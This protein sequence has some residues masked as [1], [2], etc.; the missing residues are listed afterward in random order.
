MR[1]RLRGQLLSIPALQGAWASWQ[2]GR[3]HRTYARRRE[4]YA[5]LARQ[6]GLVYR[7]EETVAAV[8]ARLAERGYTPRRR[9]AGEV[10]TFA[11]IPRIGW[12]G[13]LYN[14]LSELGPVTEFDYV[15]RGYRAEEFYTRSG[16]RRGPPARD[17]R[18]K[19][20]RRFA[21]LTSG[22]PSTGSSSTRA[23]SRSV[24]NWSV[25]S[26]RSSAFRS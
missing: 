25:P 19:P 12:H 18:R 4:R 26:S 11:F 3:L 21:Q 10:H 22:R 13:Q 15:T 24:P 2:R 16:A 17:E 7:E 23:D 5:A 1:T 14:D 6:R 9:G 20:S 8:R